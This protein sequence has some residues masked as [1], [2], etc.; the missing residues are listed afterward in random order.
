MILEKAYAKINLAL[1]VMDLIDGYHKVNNI[2]IPISLYDEIEL[3][4]ND[5]ILIV[6]DP[7]KGKNIMEKAANLFFEYTKIDGGVRII[8]KKNIPS[9]A[10]LAGGSS[11]G[12]ATLRGLN[13]LYDANLTNDELREL[14]KKLGSDVPFFIETKTAIC[15]NRGEEV[16]K[17][18]CNLD[19]TKILIIKP[20][21]GLSTKLVY[22][23]Y[24]YDGESKKESIDNIL[25][26]LKNNNSKLLKENLFNDLSLPALN[27]NK[28]MQDIYIK[29]SLVDLNPFVSGSGPTMFILNP[30]E[31]DIELVKTILDVEKCI[32]LSVNTLK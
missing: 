4:K 3:E 1:E 31:S 20:Y 22:Q 13:K 9:E 25:K 15:T 21:T 24:K 12:A 2:M 8:L 32:I 18:E 11:D 10:G 7:F 26:A 6:D 16:N 19:E 5:E 23:N 14:A 27:L 29:L 28:D 30:K 17:I